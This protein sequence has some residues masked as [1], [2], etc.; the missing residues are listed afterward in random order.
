[1]PF[2]AA[3][4][5][6]VPI[7]SLKFNDELAL[8]LVAFSFSFHF[9]FP[10]LFFLWPT[11]LLILCHGF[12]SSPGR[13]RHVALRQPLPCFPSFGEYIPLLVYLNQAEVR[14]VVQL[15]QLPTA[16]CTP[17]G[18]VSAR[19]SARTCGSQLRSA[20]ICHIV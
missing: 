17:S 1:M 2:I 9:Q 8:R 13:A 3:L 6:T 16:V 19:T 11:R 7:Y 20:L 10:H 4:H 15:V 18:K 14:R 12:S 5:C